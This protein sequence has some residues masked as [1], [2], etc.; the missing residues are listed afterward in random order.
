MRV[1]SNGPLGR[2]FR[3]NNLHGNPG[4]V[5]CDGVCYTGGTRPQRVGPNGSN[6]HSRL[7]GTKRYASLVPIASQ[8]LIL[9]PLKSLL[10]PYNS[11]GDQNVP[12][13]PP[14]LRGETR[15]WIEILEDFLPQDLR[16]HFSEGDLPPNP[17]QRPRSAL[18]QFILQARRAANVDV[19]GHL[20]VE[21]GRWTAMLWVAKVLIDMSNAPRSISVEYFTQSTVEHTAFQSLD[22]I[23]TSSFIFEPSPARNPLYSERL[24]TISGLQWPAS[25]TFKETQDIIGQIWQSLGTMI[26]FAADRNVEDSNLIISKVQQIIAIL[27]H[28]GF[29]PEMRCSVP[30]N[31]DPFTLFQPPLL[32]SLR[33]RI[34]AL[35]S[36]KFYSTCSPELGAVPNVSTAPNYTI[37]VAPA[38]ICKAKLWESS[39]AIWLEFVLWC[40]LQGGWLVEGAAILADMRKYRDSQKWSLIRW[41]E[42]AE[43]LD[44]NREDFS[45]QRL[46]AELDLDQIS[47]DTGMSTSRRIVTER[48]ISSEV[49]LAF[50]D[51]LTSSTSDSG[52]RY[53]VLSSFETIS[54]LKTLLD[55][56]KLSLYASTWDAIIVRLANSPGMQ[57]ESNP[58]M[59]ELVLTLAETN[60]KEI[61]STN[62]PP[63]TEKKST[64][65]AYV[66]EG[67]AAVLGL[68]HRTLH[69]YI[70]SRDIGGS[71]RLLLRLQSFT[72]SN[73]RKSL[74]HFFRDLKSTKAPKA[75]R[76]W[77]TLRHFDFRARF[78]GVEFPCLFPH[79][80]VNVLAEL[81]DLVTESQRYEIGHWMIYRTDVDGALISEEMY[82][83]QV[84]APAL[85]R[86]AAG[87]ADTSLLA[88]VSKA[89][90]VDVSG[91]T[92]VALCEG[93]IRLGLWQGTILVLGLIRD[94]SL[95]RWTAQDF[96][97]ILRA[98][99]YHIQHSSSGQIPGPFINQAS[100]LLQRLLRGDLG[101]VWGPTFS[102]L[103]TIAGILSSINLNLAELCTNILVRGKQYTVTLPTETFNT[104]LD[105]VVKAYGS[106]SGRKLYDTWCGESDEG[107]EIDLLDENGM[108]TKLSS[109][110]DIKVLFGQCV[111]DTASEAVHTTA[112]FKGHV[113]TEL[114]TI[115]III[116][117]ALKEHRIVEETL[118]PSQAPSKVDDEEVERQ[119]KR[120][121][122]LDWASH[123]LRHDLKLSDVDIEYELEGYSL[124]NLPSLPTDP[125]YSKQTLRIWQAFSGRRKQ[126]AL[127]HEQRLR[128][129]ATN[130]TERQLVLEPVPAAER[131]LLHCLA[132]DFK[133]KSESYGE[134]LERSVKIS[135]TA[136]AP[137][138]PSRTVDE[139]ARRAFRH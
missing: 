58:Q 40:S 100:A 88:K 82:A 35:L 118:P 64:M 106:K 3:H 34:L 69:A 49:V 15:S 101:Q 127:S 59:M 9:Q 60:G 131:F 44:L 77:G 5:F 23:T 123:T 125:P 94:Y 133:L 84:L 115:R 14:P 63:S 19:L 71:L 53:A 87:T 6:D 72:D 113:V 37:Q 134:D 43:S 111:D 29:V 129:F 139:V 51:A 26:L 119:A 39:P 18:P 83:H 76:T 67:S 116:Q 24:D 30:L 66:F 92:L 80:P 46:D 62:A 33:T 2:Y 73:Q 120:S 89:Q 28:N 22:D 117:Q 78:H 47:T 121:D 32:Q 95:H 25:Q 56:D 21:E 99:L 136:D 103:D 135:K 124:T 7:Q 138:V 20:G 132:Q 61:R 79:I 65:G 68:Y 1:R 98:L 96:A 81:L 41:T 85:I 54:K 105:G 104:I 42:I 45:Y 91:P 112:T 27:Y 126:W 93:R 86:F 52:P 137:E 102:N 70:K 57:L 130:R 4:V 31:E 90:T 8:G 38:T 36:G 109:R 55:R 74:D 50:I 97:A 12:L 122:V 128:A 110:P 75:P 13:P 16:K 11:Y 10:S 114:T 107:R 17:I 48:T 108:K